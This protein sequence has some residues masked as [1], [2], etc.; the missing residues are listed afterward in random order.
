M[1]RQKE[2]RKQ[3]SKSTL[4]SFYPVRL[5]RILVSIIQL[6]VFNWETRSTTSI[7]C[8]ETIEKSETIFLF[9]CTTHFSTVL[10]IFQI[11]LKF[12]DVFLAIHFIMWIKLFQNLYRMNENPPFIV[13]TWRKSTEFVPF[14]QFMNVSKQTFSSSIC[15]YAYLINICN[16]FW[17][18]FRQFCFTWNIS[19]CQFTFKSGLLYSN[20]NMISDSRKY[21]NGYFMMHN[22]YMPQ[23]L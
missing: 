6:Y 4:K 10:F 22:E 2:I 3:I 13:I 8:S 15:V 16:G 9:F 14:N 17:C 11:S 18:G 19:S 5:A 1:K 20:S 7:K 23:H 12:K 21:T